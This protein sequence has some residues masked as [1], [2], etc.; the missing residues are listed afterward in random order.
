MSTTGSVAISYIKDTNLYSLNQFTSVCNL[1]HILLQH[2]SEWNMASIVIWSERT[3]PHIVANL[4]HIFTMRV[5]INYIDLDQ[6]L[7]LHVSICFLLCSLTTMI[8]KHRQQYLLSFPGRDGV[9]SLE[10]QVKQEVKMPKRRRWLWYILLPWYSMCVFNSFCD[11]YSFRP[12]PAMRFGLLAEQI[13][14]VEP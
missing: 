5:F 9:R 3:H 8:Y 1:H 11:S 12:H 6:A 13:P 10:V 4:S 7:Y 14:K 2:D